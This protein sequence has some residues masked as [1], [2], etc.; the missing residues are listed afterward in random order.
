MTLDVDL[1]TNLT[2]PKLIGA[3]IEVLRPGLTSLIFTTEQL[4]YGD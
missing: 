4:H 3:F 1:M 2:V